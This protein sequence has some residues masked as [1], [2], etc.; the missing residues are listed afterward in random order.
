MAPITRERAERIA[1]AH[2][3][4]RCGEYNYKRVTIKQATK[5]QQ[6]SLGIMWSVEKVCGVCDAHLEMGIDDE[7]DIVFDS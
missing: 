7:G 6:E 4:G 5:H 2:A 1:K 3:C